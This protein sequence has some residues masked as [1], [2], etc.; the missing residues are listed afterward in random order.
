MTDIQNRI[1]GIVGRKGS[2]KSTRAATLIKY[3]PRV[4]AWDPMEDHRDLLPDWYEGF[5]GEL[6]SYLNEADRTAAF[7]CA[8]TPGDQLEAEFEEV[9]QL[10]YEHGRMLFCVE[11]APLV[12]RANYLS[13]TFGRIVRTGRHRRIDVLWTAQ[14]A[15]EVSR[16][17]TS[18][19]DVWI[20]FSQTE[21]R[22]L[23]AIAERCG[24]EIAD[25][26]ANL[27]LHGSFTW[28]VVGREVLAESPRLL[29]R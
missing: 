14:R 4:L 6:D 8:I 29:K 3:A 22:D 10:V 5:D 9:C 23:D 16:S 17:L 21:P 12:C 24:R 26:V 15:S 13:P 11:E 27:G 19:T 18:A 25:R 20:L 7:A 2:G 28:D 1:V